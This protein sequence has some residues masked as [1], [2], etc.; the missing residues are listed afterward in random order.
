MKKT[1][2]AMIV[3]IASVSVIVAF[4]ATNAIFGNTSTQEVKVKTIEKISDTEATPDPALF[5]VDAI[6]PTVEVQV[7]AGTTSPA[8]SN[9]AQTGN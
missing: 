9:Q 3:L 6:N 8:P 7:G 1:D 2:I 5:N 4:F